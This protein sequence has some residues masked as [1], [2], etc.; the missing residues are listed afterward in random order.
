MY[1][2]K[3]QVFLICKGVKMKKK[4]ILTALLALI[5]ITAAMGQAVPP[6]IPPPPPPGLPIDSGIAYLLIAGIFLGIKKRR[7]N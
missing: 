3:F 2:M 1:Y 4:I 5:G 6:P 7:K